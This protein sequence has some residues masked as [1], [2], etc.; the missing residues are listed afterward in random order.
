MACQDKHIEA[1]I[2][3]C[4]F[5]KENLWISLKLVPK[6]SIHN[7]PALG[8][9]VAWRRKSNNTIWTNDDL[10]YW[11]IY[12]SIG[13]SEL[14]LWDMLESLIYCAI[15][16][17]IE[18]QWKFAMLCSSHIQPVRTKFARAQNFVVIGWAH[19]NPERCKFWLNFE[20]DRNTASGTRPWL[21][22]FSWYT[23]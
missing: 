8:Q 16:I 2:L 22:R 12:A 10:V 4:I 3:R 9:I 20:F 21:P 17:Y 19:L 18:I 5:L 7:I 11:C 14:N 6:G 15:Y 13:L 1:D 23:Q